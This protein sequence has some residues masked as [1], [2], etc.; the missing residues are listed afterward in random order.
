MSS[1]IVQAIKQICEEKG[2]S[3]ESV[4]ITIEAALAAAYRKDFGQKNQNVKVEFDPE[5]GSM[6]AFDIKTVVRDYTEEELEEQKGKEDAPWSGDKDVKRVVVTADGMIDEKAQKEQEALPNETE[7]AE[8]EEERFNPKT[9]MMISDANKIQKGVELGEELTLE[10]EI[11]SAFGRMAAKTAKQVITQKLREAE[12]KTIFEEW[13]DKGGTIAI[14]VIGRREGNLQFVDFG[15]AAA[16]LP[17]S[18]QIERESYRSGERMKFYI[19]SVS[20]GSK[21]PAIVVSRTDPHM[22]EELFKLE[23]PEVQSGVVE[24]KAIAREAGGRAKIAVLS[25]DKNIDPIGSCI[26]QRGGRIQTVI[27]ELGGEKIDVIQW[28]EQADKFIAAALAPA[29]INN[30]ELNEEVKE[31]NVIVAE[32]ALSLAIGRAGQNVR[33]ASRLTG[34]KINII[35]EKGEVVAGSEEGQE[36]AVEKVE[37]VAE[38]KAEAE[39]N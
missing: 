3:Y 21:G 36:V 6:Q 37:E 2:L 30:V 33:L 8:P 38:E 27:A 16:I 12:R 11:P 14:G 19:K 13:S 29:K 10:L 32:E 25:N 34:W 4:M 7:T 9:M 18:E 35:G 31:A 26:G 39:K 28:D 20:M 22:V 15:R 1:P 5:T 24:I 23:I 17:M